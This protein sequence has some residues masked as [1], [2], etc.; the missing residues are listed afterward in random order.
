MVF[1]GW[2]AAIIADEFVSRS[3]LI[4]ANR[5]GRLLFGAQYSPSTII[6]VDTLQQEAGTDTQ[7]VFNPIDEQQKSALT[8]K[9][10]LTNGRTFPLKKNGLC[11]NNFISNS[12]YRVCVCACV[13][14][15]SYPV[16][17]MCAC[18]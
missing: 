6:A 10:G 12:K 7:V 13:V 9:V 18:F 5:H 16:S 2:S 8:S 3:D 15:V 1:V 14:A 4:Y 17:S 11:R